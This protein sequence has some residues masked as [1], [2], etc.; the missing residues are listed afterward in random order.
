MPPPAVKVSPVLLPPSVEFAPM[1]QVVGFLSVAC[2]VV[3]APSVSRLP[4]APFRL[5][6]V[7]SFVVPLVNS[8][9]PM[10]VFVMLANL[11]EPLI[12]SAPVPP[13]FKVG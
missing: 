6:A 4:E 2:E 12:V 1:Y 10:T 11:L 13:W 5:N 8:T 9:E 7:N 3:V